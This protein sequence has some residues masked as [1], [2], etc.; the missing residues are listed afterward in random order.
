[1]AFALVG[2]RRARRPWPVGRAA[3]YLSLP[4]VASTGQ[5]REP[6]SP[7]RIIAA[8]PMAKTSRV[9]S[10]PRR[11]PVRGSPE[12]GGGVAS[13]TGWGNSRRPKT[14]GRPHGHRTT[15]AGDC[16]GRTS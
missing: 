7:V 5:E 13:C 9:A 11:R 1:V 10:A 15:R 8:E 16:A 6:S 4:G 2:R 3:D 14:T 12:S